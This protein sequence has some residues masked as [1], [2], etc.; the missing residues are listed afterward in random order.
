MTYAEQLE[1]LQRKRAELRQL[2]RDAER[3]AMRMR[4][5]SET[6]ERQML[7][8]QA[9]V[10]AVYM[11]VGLRAPSPGPGVRPAGYARKLAIGLQNCSGR[12]RGADLARLDDA[13]F[14][15]AAKQIE[16]DARKVGPR[17]GLAEDEVKAISKNVGG[18]IVTEFVAHEGCSNWFG[19]PFTR[20]GRALLKSRADYNQLSAGEAMRRVTQRIW[21]RPTVQAPRS[22]F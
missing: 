16:A 10:D 8:S 21:N 18:A 12:W 4:P 2:E 22:A 14:E 3:E 15:I 5:L 13:A 7:A 17:A 19:K 9:R 20:A 6:D 1:Q 11:D